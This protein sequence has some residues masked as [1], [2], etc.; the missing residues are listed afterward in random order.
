MQIEARFISTDKNRCEMTF[1]KKTYNHT[2]WTHTYRINTKNGFTTRVLEHGDAES[3]GQLHFCMTNDGE[4]CCKFFKKFWQWWMT[5]R[6]TERLTETH[7]DT[8]WHSETY[9]ECQTDWDWD[10]DSFWLTGLKDSL[11][12]WKCGSPS[13]WLR[14]QTLNSIWQE[15]SIWAFWAKVVH[16]DLL[17]AL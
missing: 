5:V 8:I 11:R 17:G 14:I 10:W 1:L 12:N 6:V 3:P 13:K 7:W 4:K 16:L 9:W 2:S 15:W